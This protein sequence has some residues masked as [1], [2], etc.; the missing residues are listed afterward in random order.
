MAYKEHRVKISAGQ[1]RKLEKM[2]RGGK[3]KQIVL[4]LK[5]GELDGDDVF[6]FTSSQF[7]KIQR[8]KQ[9]KRGGIIKM[10]VCQIKANL[11]VEGG[12][13][14]MIAGLLSRF[15]PTIIK[16]VAPNLLGG[17]ATGLVSGAVEKAVS[18]HGVFLQKDQ[19]CY[20]VDAVEGNG[21]YLSPH[22]RLDG[23]YEDNNYKKSIRNGL[24]VLARNG[25][26]FNGEG[27]LLGESSPF[28]NIPI[29][30]WIL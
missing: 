23:V 29:L 15:L 30:G 1:K 28:K 7:K 3:K 2:A 6:L 13:L 19:H 9:M 27:L 14:S 10:S 8:A 12:F 4:Q 21:L 25:R 5:K 17:L 18:G 20:K 11:R 26:I 22:P 16:K 24:F